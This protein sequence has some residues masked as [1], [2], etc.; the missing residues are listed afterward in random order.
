VALRINQT[1]RKYVDAYRASAV[2][3]NSDYSW[4]VLYCND[5]AIIFTSTLV[6]QQRLYRHPHTFFWFKIIFSI[7]KKIVKISSGKNVQIGL[8]FGW[9]QFDPSGS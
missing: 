9:S 2:R 1:R 7:K 6:H 5:T 3:A 4:F 8:G